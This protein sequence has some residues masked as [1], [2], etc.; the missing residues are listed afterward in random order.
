MSKVLKALAL[1]ALVIG[2]NGAMFVVT[3]ISNAES[4]VY[5]DDAAWNCYTMGNQTCGVDTY[6]ESTKG[7][8]A[9]LPAANDGGVYV[10]WPDGTVTPATETQRRAAWNTCVDH[11]T[12]TDASLQQC[13]ADFQNDGDRFTK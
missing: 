5:E 2:I 11:A 13:D 9:V 10:S 7:R 4:V 8:G 3:G 12:G 6:F 1:I